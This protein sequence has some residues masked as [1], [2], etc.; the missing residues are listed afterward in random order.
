MHQPRH[1][2]S[3]R[4]VLG[5]ISHGEH[6]PEVRNRLCAAEHGP[7]GQTL[8]LGFANPS[9][10]LESTLFPDKPDVPR[11][12]D[13][14]LITLGTLPSRQRSTPPTPEVSN[15]FLGFHPQTLIWTDF[16][17]EKRHNSATT[18]PIPL[19]QTHKDVY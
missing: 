3:D 16:R 8:T 11:T 14:C 12:V 10:G 1:K 4:T 15:N 2:Y 6:D 19:L 5:H 17:H 13:T 18:T 9:V 7:I